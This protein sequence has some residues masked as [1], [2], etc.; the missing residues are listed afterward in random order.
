MSA[1]DTVFIAGLAVETR[2][3]I[4]AGERDATQTVVLDLELGFDNTRPATSGRIGDTVDYAA[5]AAALKS[6]IAA[7]DCGLLEQL[8][9]AC[10]TMLRDQ[11]RGIRSV[12][13][14]LDKPAAAQALGCARVGVRIQR[15]FA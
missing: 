5:V 3:G 7:S 4:Y 6:F 10:C 1:M 15:Q 8:A 14:R 9:E 12:D 11:F 13:L 2:I